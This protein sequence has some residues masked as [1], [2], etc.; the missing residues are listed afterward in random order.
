MFITLLFQKK[1]AINNTKE[2]N[3][4]YYYNLFPHT[5]FTLMKLDLILFTSVILFLEG[6]TSQSRNYYDQYDY[7]SPPPP[8]SYRRIR[9]ENTQQYRV[10]PPR[11]PLG[12]KAS[13][14]QAKEQLRYFFASDKPIKASVDTLE[15]YYVDIDEKHMKNLHPRRKL[16][17]P[18]KVLPDPQPGLVNPMLVKPVHRYRPL[19]RNEKFYGKF[20][21]PISFKVRQ[22]EAVVGSLPS[23][24]QNYGPAGMNNRVMYNDPNGYS[25]PGNND[26]YNDRM[27]YIY[28]DQFNGYN[29]P[30]PVA[31]PVI[32]KE[33]I[34]EPNPFYGYRKQEHNP[35]GDYFQKKPAYP[36]R[37]LRGENHDNYQHNY[38]N[39]KHSHNHNHHGR[40]NHHQRT[41]YPSERSFNT[42]TATAMPTD[43]AAKLSSMS[44]ALAAN[45]ASML[46]ASL[47]A[48]IA[49]MS[50]AWARKEASLKAK[51]STMSISATPTTS[52]AGWHW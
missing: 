25:Y 10:D 18:C 42:M 38:N 50:S 23:M 20:A 9:S 45:S 5:H 14:Q 40:N 24:K 29:N 47:N 44:A 27:N 13:M 21:P 16:K 43:M 30:P 51:L 36:T 15:D 1:E 48:K 37:T 26:R 8:A 28:N 12:Y 31:Y 19:Y 46:S 22:Q 7:D 32:Q 11:R 4:I 2:Y 6:T 17:R 39:N 52:R 34:Y 41:N 49:S 33:T 35:S 3:N